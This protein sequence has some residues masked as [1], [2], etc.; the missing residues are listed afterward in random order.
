MF[1]PGL[2]SPQRQAAWEPWDQHAVQFTPGPLPLASGKGFHHESGEGGQEEA[3]GG[4]APGPRGPQQPP[5]LCAE[6]LCPAWRGQDLGPAPRDPAGP[7]VTG[8]AD[9]TPAGGSGPPASRGQRQSPRADRRAPSH[10][11]SA[12]PSLSS[13]PFFVVILCLYEKNIFFQEKSTGI[14]WHPTPSSTNE[15]MCTYIYIPHTAGIK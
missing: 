6:P 12:S 5:E 2:C 10:F 13:L 14:K 3:G 4:A 8:E 9:L 11:L 15:H 1:H 7:G